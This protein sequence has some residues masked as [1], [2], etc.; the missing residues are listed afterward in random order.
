M[1]EL[2]HRLEIDPLDLRLA[3]LRRSRP[4]DAESPGRRRSCA[5]PTRKAR[6]SSAGAS[7]RASRRATATGSVGHGMATCT[8]G[9][10]RNPREARVAAAE[11]TDG[12]IETGTQDIG[13]GT[14]T[15][16]P[17]IAADVLGLP[18]ESGRRLRWATRACREAG[19][20]YG[21]SSTMGVGSAVLRAA[22]EMRAQAADSPIAPTKR[23]WRRTHSPRR[24]DGV[25]QRRWRSGRL[26][27]RRRR[28]VHAAETR[29]QRDG[30]GTPY[31]M[32]TFGAVFVEVGVDPELGLLR[33][34]RAVGSY[35]AGRIINPRTAKAQMTG[36]IIW[37]WGMAAMEQ[38]RYE[39]KLG[40]CLSKNL[41]G[42]AIPVHADIPA[43]ID[44]PLRRR[45]R[46]AREPARR[47]G[48]RRA[49][50]HRRRGR[51]CQR[52]FPCDRQTHPRAADHPGQADRCVG[53]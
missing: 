50:C 7:G 37:G 45:G 20:T 15:I 18:V 22:Q 27:D 39:P 8:M 2:A 19:P 35:S 23:R 3:Q 48:H 31:A 46:R 14:L 38:S 16:F 44:D 34:R 12:V 51:R 25:D 9:N 47:Q 43:D 1:D 41:S 17:Q 33:L 40:R 10:F 26:R 42:V 49:G 52:R 6:D 13:T 32:R 36:G 24:L 28:H 4:G 11:A 5:R 29:V 53:C 30:E 21:S